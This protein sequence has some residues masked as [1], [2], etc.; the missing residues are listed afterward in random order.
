MTSFYFVKWNLWYTT[1]MSTLLMLG[2][3]NTNLGDDSMIRILPVLVLPALTF[4]ALATKEDKNKD[5]YNVA[6]QYDKES[7]LLNKSKQTK[8]YGTV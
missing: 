6:D 8:Y 4:I 5:K 2:L 7:V 1:L 3:T